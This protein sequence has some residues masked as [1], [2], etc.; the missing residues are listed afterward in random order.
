MNSPS[1]GTHGGSPSGPPEGHYSRLC[2]IQGREYDLGKLE[3]LARRMKDSDAKREARGNRIE[4]MMSGYV[5][6]GQFIDHDLTRDQTLLRDVNSN[7]EATPNYRTP[8]LDLDHLYGKVPAD[9]P[10]IYQGEGEL[11]IDPTWPT[12][13]PTGRRIPQTLDDLPRTANGTAEVIDPRSDENLVIAQIHVLFAKLHNRLLELGKSRPGLTKGI[14]GK[15]AFEKTRRLVTWHYQWIIVN[16]FLP[17]FVK[18]DVL[19]TVFQK[20]QLRLYTHVCTPKDAPIALPVEFTVAAYRFGHSM[21]QEVY[22]LNQYH[23]VGTGP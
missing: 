7:V 15:D 19:K 1:H 20:R 10:N 3:E 22:I 11:R 12:T 2:P 18:A 8:C 13:L 21:V 4:A 5:Y 23:L 17:S 6:L 14:S 16:D 9:V